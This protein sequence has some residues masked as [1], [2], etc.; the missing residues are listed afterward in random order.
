M[1]NYCYFFLCLLYSSISVKAQTL[2]VSPLQLNFGPTTELAADSQ[3]VMLTNSSGYTVTVT[4]CHFYNTYGSPAFSTRAGVITIPDGSSQSIWIVFQPLHNIQHNTELI[5][6]S[7]GQ[8]GYSRVDLLGQGHY[9]KNY[10]NN[11]EN[12]EEE[13]L[14]SALNSITGAGYN[15]LGYNPARDS[16]FMAIDNQKTNGQGATQNTLECVYT[17]RQAVGY[18]DRTDCQTNDNFNTEHTFPQGFFASAEPMKSD[19]YHIFPTDDVA[20]NV[21][22]NF[23]FGIVSSPTWNQGG[24][25]FDGAIFEPRDIHKGEVARAMM[26]FVIRY[27]DYSNFFQPQQPVLKAWNNQYAPT[28][29][30]LARENRIALSQGN[31]NPFID[32]PQFADRITTFSGLS[33]STDQTHLNLP[34]D[35]INFGTINAA[36][37]N[38]YRFWLVNDGNRAIDI[39]NL[40]VTPNGVLFFANSTGV[41]ATIQ[42]GEA[43]GLDISLANAIPGSFNGFLNF[44]ATGPG[45]LANVTVPIT[46]N[47]SLTAIGETPEL[48]SPKFYPNPFHSG[49]CMEP[50]PAANSLIQLIDLQGRIARIMT[51]NGE[52][53]VQIPEDIVSG[54]YI[55]QIKSSS[56]TFHQLM[57][58]E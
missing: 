16:M 54:T 2:T 55:I 9:S 37:V 32:Y 29:I 13:A 31:R 45:L 56:R 58:K 35:S 48:L 11:S 40:N 34:D 36:L 14:K 26:Y 41:N 46:A 15:S 4:G 39:T 19:L 20:N 47:L 49:V 25:K 24:S 8:N 12:F 33:V 22:A 52:G 21:R 10:F 1:K 5:I 43:L 30:E 38:N 23:P 51:T 27:Q 3:Q 7:D 18:I 28:A 57:I 44:T 42:S 17:G 53:C 6:E 50:A